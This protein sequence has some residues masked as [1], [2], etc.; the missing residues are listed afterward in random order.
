MNKVVVAAA[1]EVSNRYHDLKQM[2][3]QLLREARAG[4]RGRIREAAQPEKGWSSSDEVEVA[5]RTCDEAIGL[6][7]TDIKSQRL[8][9]I[10]DAL[11]RLEQGEYGL[12]ADCGEEIAANR[13]RAD[14]AVVRCR[15]CEER[16]ENAEKCGQPMRKHQNFYN[17]F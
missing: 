9:K 4:V 8:R 11:A 17:L 15:D 14:P 3:E 12:C 2:L 5:G 6:K 10:E 13:L 1:C 16:R 7:V